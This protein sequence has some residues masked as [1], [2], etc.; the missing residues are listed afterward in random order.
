MTPFLIE[1]TSWQIPL[2]AAVGEKTI[3]AVHRQQ[4]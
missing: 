3:M 4:K 2:S 1:A